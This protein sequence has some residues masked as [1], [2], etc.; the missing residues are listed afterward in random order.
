MRTIKKM[1]DAFA[2]GGNLSKNEVLN[3]IDFYS[4]LHLQLEPLDVFTFGDMQSIVEQRIQTLMN[5]IQTNGHLK[6]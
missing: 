1:N 5:R 3:L 6:H 4:N 2:N